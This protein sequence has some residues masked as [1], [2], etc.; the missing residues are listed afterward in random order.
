ML[1][2]LTK[3]AVLWS[4]NNFKIRNSNRLVCLF[5]KRTLPAE[6]RPVSALGTLPCIHPP[7]TSSISHVQPVIIRADLAIDQPAQTIGQQV[8]FPF[9][10]VRDVA[11]LWCRWIGY[12]VTHDTTWNT[13]THKFHVTSIVPFKT[14]SNNWDNFATGFLSGS[15]EGRVAKSYLVDVA[16]SARCLSFLKK[17]MLSEFLLPQG[18]RLC[19]IMYECRNLTLF[20]EIYR[21][22]ENS[23]YIIRCIGCFE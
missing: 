17:K 4:W 13:H 5:S 11:Q 3:I 19:S 12:G 20:V 10:V 7:I 18:C 21:G 6:T 22:Y 23:F 2:K 15:V 9:T 1:Q 16:S 8:V 14:N